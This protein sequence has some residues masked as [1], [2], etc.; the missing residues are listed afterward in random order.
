MANYLSNLFLPFCQIS[1]S[2][3]TTRNH[4]F[5][6]QDNFAGHGTKIMFSFLRIRIL[7]A[8]DHITLIYS[9]FCFVK[10]QKRKTYVY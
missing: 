4:I 3:I 9:H 2:T 7:L 8:F 1:K 5:P 10:V 6:T